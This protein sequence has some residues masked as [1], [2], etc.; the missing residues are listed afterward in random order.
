MMSCLPSIYGNVSEPRTVLNIEEWPGFPPWWWAIWR[1]WALT[2]I[3]RNTGKLK[4]LE[5]KEEILYYCLSTVTNTVFIRKTNCG[6]HNY[7]ISPIYIYAR[8]NQRALRS[9][10]DPVIGPHACSL[11]LL[12]GALLTLGK[13]QRRIPRCRDISCSVPSGTFK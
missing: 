11:A 12:R 8:H 6:S 13:V 1:T 4:L 5:N 9:F 2:S 10:L 3:G 7:K